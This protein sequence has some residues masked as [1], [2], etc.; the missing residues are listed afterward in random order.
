MRAIPCLDPSTSAQRLSASQRGASEE[1]FCKAHRSTVL[2]AFRH[3]RGGHQALSSPGCGSGACAQRLS[4]SQR[5]ASPDHHDAFV[6]LPSAQRL[7]ASQRGASTADLVHGLPGCSTP[8]GITEVG[9]VWSR[10]ARPDRPCAQR[11]SAS[12]RGA[13]RPASVRAAGPCMCSTPFGIT[14]VGIISRRS[15]HATSAQR[16]SA[17][18]RSASR[19]CSVTVRAVELVLNA[20]R[21]HRGGHAPAFGRTW[22]LAWCSTPFGITEGGISPY[23]PPCRAVR[24]VLNAFRHHRGGHRS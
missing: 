22:P 11:L 10:A 18:Q 13:S 17:S 12:Q 1:D 15:I 20:F 8:F 21:H 14:E 9:I 7:S 6:R 23:V 3:H 16:L 5:G 19:P 4:A 24:S 2:N